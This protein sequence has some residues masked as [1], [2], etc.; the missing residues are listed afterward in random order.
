ML[1]LAHPQTRAVIQ[2]A[3]GEDYLNYYRKRL[4]ISRFL[5]THSV[6]EARVSSRWPALPL[7]DPARV[8]IPFVD[9][10]QNL[11]YLMTE[12][13][14]E[15]SDLKEKLISYERLYPPQVRSITTPVNTDLIWS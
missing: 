10:P 2:K 1:V 5:L 15:Y 13:W 4:A 9:V 12:T 3:Y 14:P 7:P 6:E 8:Y 11:D